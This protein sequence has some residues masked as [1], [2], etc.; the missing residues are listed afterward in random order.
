MELI[1]KHF[2]ELDIYELYKILALRESVFIVEQNCI[3][4][5]IDGKDPEC[6]HLMAMDGKELASLTRIVPP[7]ISY[8]LYSSIGRV[9]T[10][11]RYRR[12]GLSRMLMLKSIEICSGLF[13][14]FDIKISAQTYL[15]PYYQSLSFEK[16]GDEYLEDDMPHQAMIRPV[17]LDAQ[18]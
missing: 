7:K 1:L 3:Y 8:D 10:H 4:Q 13:P 11:S 15:I 17:R 16:T 2:R 14:G 9:V 6:Y 12:K 5:D 18:H